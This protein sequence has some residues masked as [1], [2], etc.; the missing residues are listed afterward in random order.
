MPSIVIRVRKW[1]DE[2][3]FNEL[4]KI[5]DYVGRESGYS[6]Y[7]LNVSKA[8]KNGYDDEEAIELLRR[9]GADLSEKELE[10]LR[11][12]FRRELEKT[13]IKIELLY[14][15]GEVII[16]P[17]RYLGDS[18][19][20]IRDLLTYD[21]HSKVF[22]TYPIYYQRVKEYLSSIGAKI[23][24]KTGFS[25]RRLVAKPVLRVSLRDYQDEAVKKWI[26]NK[27]RGIIALPTGSGKTIVGLAALSELSRW[28]LVV[29]YTKEQVKQWREQ[30][31][32]NLGLS[33]SDV[34]V[35]YGEE[36]RIAP[37]T[38]TTYQTAFRY[39]NQLSPYFSLLIIDEC[40]HLPADKFREIAMKSFAPYR[41]GLSA[42]PFR[43]DG[44]HEEL[45]PLL[46]GVIYYKSA[47]EL[48]ERGFLAPFTVRVIKVDLTPEEAKL[49]RE[50]KKRY[51][52][53]SR[54]LEFQELL[55]LA[56]KGDANAIEAIKVRSQLRLLVHTAKEKI[57]ALR[58]VFYEELNKGSKIIIFTQYIDQAEEIGKILG[59]PVITGE[60]DPTTRKRNFDLFRSGVHRALVI[61]SVG[62][63]GIDIP[64]ANVGIII[65]G[66]SSRRQFLQRLGRLL[67][68]VENKE[69]VLYEIIVRNTFEEFESK[70][71]RSALKLLEEDLLSGDEERIF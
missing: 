46:G 36:K 45:F 65:A 55:A 13:L 21:K 64:D 31:I 69:A 61:T 29:A 35:F 30:L 16:K 3:D 23:D 1:L 42:T 9:I 6:V 62:D 24:D 71:R 40:H 14:S 54:G 48:A 32:R 20:G 33:Q 41:L 38:V 22:K 10:D 26:D 39:I 50:L 8:I 2:E 37:V 4:L 51:E 5:S 57:E 28:S 58:R 49:Y 18:L 27:Y 12:M 15:S 43:E 66:T 11:S 47:K 67:R 63:E 56:K 53:L 60:T 70:K 52:E 19:S 68:P 34:G 59:V 44:R 7:S 17:D 25:E